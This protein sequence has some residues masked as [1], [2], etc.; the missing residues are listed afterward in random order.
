[1][2]SSKHETAVQSTLMSE[3]VAVPVT[4]SRLTSADLLSLVIVPSV[5]QLSRLLHSRAKI[6]HLVIYL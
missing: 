3:P 4:H 6:H 2:S 1:M 5:T